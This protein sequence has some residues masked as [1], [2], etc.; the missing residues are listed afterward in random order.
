MTEEGVPG[1]V[2]EALEDLR[3]AD[4]PLEAA[5]PV[6]DL[7][8]YVELDP[9]RERPDP[10]TVEHPKGGMT[11]ARFPTVVM[12]GAAGAALAYFLDPNSGEQRRRRFGRSLREATRQ[13]RKQVDS[14]AR[15]IRKA[16]G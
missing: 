8:Q 10:R 6:E 16:A 3:R 7:D 9:I 14:T 15:T 2:R 12:A 1:A 4:P 5:L 13:G 11:V